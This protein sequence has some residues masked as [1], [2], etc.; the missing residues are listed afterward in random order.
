M[1]PKILTV[2]DVDPSDKIENLEEKIIQEYLK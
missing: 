2:F 1:I